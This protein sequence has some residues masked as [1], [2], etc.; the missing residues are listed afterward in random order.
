MK[1]PEL[2]RV[3]KEELG[4][5]DEEL[6]DALDFYGESAH[7]FTREETLGFEKGYRETIDLDARDELEFMAGHYVSVP[8]RHFIETGNTNVS[9]VMKGRRVKPLGPIRP[10][11]EE[12]DPLEKMDFE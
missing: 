1:N 12:L 7:G 6:S 3:L 9:A 8:G 5:K 4:L 11:W 10:K 2:V